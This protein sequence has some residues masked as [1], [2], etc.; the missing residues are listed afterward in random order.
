MVSTHFPSSCPLR[1]PLDPG[2]DIRD[3]QKGTLQSGEKKPAGRGPRPGGTAQRQG[4]CVPPTHRGRPPDLLAF[5]DHLIRNRSSPRK[6]LLFPEQVGSPVSTSDKTTASLAEWAVAGE[7]LFFPAV[8]ENPPLLS[9]ILSGAG[10]I[11]RDMAASGVLLQE[12]DLF[13]QV[14]NPSLAL[15]R[16]SL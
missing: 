6:L 16:W 14:M 4:V 2:N 7:V 15:G 9:E 13:P 10:R 11:W 3:G 12:V 8:P 1:T 5:S